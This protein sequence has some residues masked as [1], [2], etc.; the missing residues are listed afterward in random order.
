MMVYNGGD[1][2]SCSIKLTGT[3]KLRVRAR[4]VLRP[5]QRAYL[6][7]PDFSYLPGEQ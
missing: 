3:A 4:P 6:S 5:L 7:V 2:T 1:G